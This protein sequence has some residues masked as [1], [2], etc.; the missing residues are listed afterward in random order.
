MPTDKQKK[1]IRDT[2][3]EMNRKFAALLSDWDDLP[4]EEIDRRRQEIASLKYRIIE[5]LDYT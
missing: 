4:W 1:R 2:L 3:V 5:D